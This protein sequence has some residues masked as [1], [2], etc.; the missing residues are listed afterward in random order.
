MH[1]LFSYTL[2]RKLCR[3]NRSFAFF[4]R[5]F[6]KTNVVRLT[7]FL[8]YGEILR[9]YERQRKTMNIKKMI[10][11]AAAAVMALIM[12]ACANGGS[13][14]QSNKP[15]AGG[16]SSTMNNST[17][18]TNVSVPSASSPNTP[19]TDVSEFEY[20]YDSELCGMVITKYKGRSQNVW[21]PSEIDGKKVVSIYKAFYENSNVESVVIP[22]SV[23]MI[24]E[25]AFCLCR[26]ITSM[27]IPD[28]VTEIGKTAFSHCT[29]LASINIPKGVTKIDNSA[30]VNCCDLK[31]VIISDSVT[32]IE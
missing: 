20:E 10:A 28:S 16:S 26:G 22:D 19:V 14:V 5:G 29:K 23:T 3:S 12:T 2:E 13:E 17:L 27:T 1:A 15:N 32:E 11:A 7:H 30:F 9:V 21:I 24:G 25:S 4:V 6:A 8:I 31:N 18:S